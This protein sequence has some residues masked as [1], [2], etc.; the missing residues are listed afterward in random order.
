MGEQVADQTYR[1]AL[2]VIEKLRAELADARSEV[3]SPVAVVGMGCRYPGGADDP[4]QYWDTLVGKVDGVGEVPADRWDAD[5]YFD[6]QGG[7]G[8]TISRWGGFLED[9]DQFD[10][11][12]FQLSVREAVEMD[13]NQRLAMEVTWQALEDAGLAGRVA[14]TRTGIYVGVIGNDYAMTYFTDPK[15]LSAYAATGTAHSILSGRLAYLLDTRGPAVSI[16]AACSS[17]LIAIFEACR[18]L[19]TH[20]CDVALAG[21]V[22]VILSPLPSVAFSQF[23]ML[24]PTGRCRSFDAAGDGF[25]RSEGCGMVVLKRLADAT[26]DGDRILAVI[27]GGAMNQDGRSTGLTAPNVDSQRT[28][29]REA[30]HSARLQASQVSYVEAHGTGTAIGDPIEAAALSDV[31]RADEGDEWFLGSVKSNLGHMEA[32]AG[33]AGFTKVVL[34]LQH[35]MIPPNL[36]FEQLNPLVGS[37]RIPFRIP[38][39]S[40]PWPKRG[41]LRVGGVSSF[42]LSGTNVHLLLEEAPEPAEVSAD[43]AGETQLLALSAASPVALQELAGLHA[44]ALQDNSRDL[45]DHC[46][47]TITGRA[48]FPYRAAVV[49]ATREQLLEG[50]DAIRTG[51]QVN[52]A[53]GRVPKLGLVV[54]DVSHRPIDGVLDPQGSGIE[55]GWAIQIAMVESWSRVGLEPAV[56][57]GFGSGELL[58]AVL[59]G[60]IDLATAQ[61]LAA[62]ARQDD[63]AALKEVA[64]AVQAVAPRTRWYSHAVGRRMS[65]RELQDPCLWS[66]LASAATTQILGPWSIDE[67]DCETLLVLGDVEAVSSSVPM[68]GA[69]AADQGRTMLESLASLFLAGARPDWSGLPSTGRHRVSVPL[70]PHD[71]TRI[72]TSAPSG[73]RDTTSQPSDEPMVKSSVLGGSSIRG[74]LLA[75]APEQRFELLARHLEVEI[76]SALGQDGIGGDWGLPLLEMGLDSLMALGIRN[77]LKSDLDVDLSVSSLLRDSSITSITTAVLEELERPAEE[78]DSSVSAG[79]GDDLLAELENLPLD[80]ARALLGGAEK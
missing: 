4:Q 42:G 11:S 5:A 68:L 28:L 26:A 40:V 46:W 47:S 31:Y 19:Q 63:P 17:S 44:Q 60:S 9:I 25:V 69:G 37:G 67:A 15:Y 20:D 1:K 53:P 29:L 35:R 80:E 71:R 61:R 77:R 74:K 22:N 3:F 24:S 56:V 75:A 65:P 59:A 16:D 7:P 54:A 66:Q 6:P 78:M 30:L 18:A 50:L 76:N 79:F 41:G 64:S 21:G 36:H 72:W 14:G 70:T 13:P 38:T 58:A 33:V 10:P 45:A 62:V 73:L 32:A 51:P 52:S 43:Q 39:E 48:Q 49:G 34:G 2:A 8:R 27:R 55:R 12:F 23:G 57:H